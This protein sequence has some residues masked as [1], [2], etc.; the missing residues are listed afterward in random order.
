MILYSVDVSALLGC[1]KGADLLFPEHALGGGPYDHNGIPSRDG[2]RA[3]R[4]GFF[5]EDSLQQNHGWY[6]QLLIA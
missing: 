5:V 1:E 3:G 2:T 4:A 6:P